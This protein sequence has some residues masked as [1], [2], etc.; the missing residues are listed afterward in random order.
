MR[1][2]ALFLLALI[3][4][5]VFPSPA[6]S[7]PK[8]GVFEYLPPC[9]AL[10]VDGDASM[11]DSHLDM[12]MERMANVAEPTVTLE[13]APGTFQSFLRNLTSLG[14]FDPNQYNQIRRYELHYRDVPLVQL[15]AEQDPTYEIPNE[16]FLTGQVQVRV[17]RDQVRALSKLPGLVKITFSESE[18]IANELETRHR[19]AL[20]DRF[21][22][23]DNSLLENSPK[24][25]KALREKPEKRISVYFEINGTPKEFQAVY[26]NAVANGLNVSD[27]YYVD[28][29]YVSEAGKF[30]HPGDNFAY[31]VVKGTP[32]QI[33]SVLFVARYADVRS[34]LRTKLFYKPFLKLARALD[35]RQARKMG[36]LESDENPIDWI[37]RKLKEEADD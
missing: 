3:H 28:V 20:T 10:L 15:I 26:A 33:L 31:F 30:R 13:A 2:D 4:V 6:F 21:T 22:G 32:K 34:S 18:N 7:A 37:A 23:I 27:H 12:L 8:R 29:E 25:L 16:F 11:N 1:L 5:F 36:L 35:V 14:L 24:L 19:L 17:H 9:R